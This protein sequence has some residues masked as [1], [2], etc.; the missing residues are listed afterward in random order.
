MSHAQKLPLLKR[1]IEFLS[2][3]LGISLSIRDYATR[4]GY[5]K[6]EDTY[7]Y[8]ISVSYGSEVYEFEY[9]EDYLV[10]VGTNSFA[11]DLERKCPFVFFRSITDSQKLPVQGTTKILDLVANDLQTRAED[12]KKKYGKYL[13]THNG[14]DALIDA[15]QE[16]LDLCMYLRQ[17]IEERNSS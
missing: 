1:K 11:S 12:G 5:T 8:I 6:S 15:Y 17:A 3:Q 2:K 9:E 16:A 10:N 14:R 4:M 13:Q 7:T